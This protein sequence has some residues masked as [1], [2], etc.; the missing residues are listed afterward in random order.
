MHNNL[1][2]IVVINGIIGAMVWVILML[3]I[4]IRQLKI[5]SKT[6]P[7]EFLNTIAMASFVSMVAFQISG[8]TEWNFGDAE[9][10]VVMWF[11]FSL[12][13]VAEKLFNRTNA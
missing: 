8:L 1:M 4:F 10:A 2:Q 9:F 13:F 12:A 7:N 3:Y 6:K 5:Y 11:N